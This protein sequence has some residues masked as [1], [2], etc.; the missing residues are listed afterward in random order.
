MANKQKNIPDAIDYNDDDVARVGKKASLSPGNRRFA[1]I[2]A[3]RD[4]SKNDH[5]MIN[6]E[7]AA[8]KDPEDAGTKIKPTIRHRLTLPITNPTA[9]NH[10]AP[11]TSG[12][13]YAFLR[14][15]E[16]G[17]DTPDEVPAK[18]FRNSGDA[19]EFEGHEV[20]D[21]DELKEAYATCNRKMLGALK[22]I[23]ADP[24]ILIDYVFYGCVEENGD[25]SNIGDVWAD[26]PSDEELVDASDAST[27]AAEGTA[28]S[29][30]GKK[31]AKAKKGAQANGEV[32][33]A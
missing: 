2:N 10:K 3:E 32:T 27:F 21:K 30:K 1:I 24:T 25:Y 17:K 7:C 33:T 19:M 23:W 18:P 14:A 5:L 4:V 22:S 29:K 11:N 12:F 28:T 20:A 8:L 26:L 16:F 6:I 15:I 31:A 9:A 13:C